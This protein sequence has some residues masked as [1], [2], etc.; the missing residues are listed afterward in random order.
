[1]EVFWYLRLNPNLIYSVD[2]HVSG[3]MRIR[4]SDSPVLKCK[5]FSFVVNNEGYLVKLLDPL[6]RVN[7]FC[8]PVYIS[9]PFCPC[10]LNICPVSSKSLLSAQWVAKFLHADSEDSDQTENI[11]CISVFM[12][13]SVHSSHFSMHTIS[14]ELCVL[15]VLKFHI[16]IPHGKIAD[17]Y[18]FLVRHISL[19]GF[20]SL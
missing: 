2:F 17:Q 5:G 6:G 11:P 4:T 9:G 19:S 20:T 7:V 10:K 14:Y 16:W 3:Y 13:P 8:C 18:F 12:H 1:M 15:R